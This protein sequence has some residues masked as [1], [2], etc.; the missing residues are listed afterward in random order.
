MGIDAGKLIAAAA[1]ACGMVFG[2]AGAAQAAQPW[3]GGRMDTGLYL[4]AGVGQSNSEFDTTG[5]AGN[6]DDKDIGWKL[7]VGYQFSR[8]FAVEGGY[9]D[10]GK[11][12]FNGTLT[13]AVPPF[14]AGTATSGR[15][16]SRA[17]ALSA[18]GTLPLPNNFAL[19]GR[20]GVAIGDQ[21]VDVTTGGLTASA[22]DDTTEL[23]YGLGV[24]YYFNRNV[25]VRAS[26]DRFRVGG[27]DVGGKNDVDLFAIDFLYRFE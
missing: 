26:W 14:A 20:V 11:T 4:G 12:S 2:G 22:S 7:F 23:T 21:E 19:L 13:T 27:S 10:L 16:K 5:F 24:R 8:Y 9:Y 18:V 1:L 15:I 17:Y 25:G 3:M 6:V